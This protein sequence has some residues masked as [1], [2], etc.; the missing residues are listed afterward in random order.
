MANMI[1]EVRETS[2]SRW[3]APKTNFWNQG[4]NL[5]SWTVDIFHQEKE[6]EVLSYG[7][8]I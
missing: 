8:I 7:V 4:E 2:N 5:L 3:A 1:S 6:T